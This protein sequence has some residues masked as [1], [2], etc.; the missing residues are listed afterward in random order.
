MGFGECEKTVSRKKIVLQE[1]GRK[2]TFLNNGGLKI[3]K[4]EVDGCAINGSKFER[5]IS[6]TLSYSASASDS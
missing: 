4:V 3:R 2:I 6:I 1:K 5:S